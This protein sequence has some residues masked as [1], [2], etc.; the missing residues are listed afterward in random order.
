M[1]KIEAEVLEVAAHFDED[2][3]KPVLD[4]R[5]K[6]RL[7]LESV[8]DMSNIEGDDKVE[9]L[10]GHEVAMALKRFDARNK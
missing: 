4:V 2:T 6:M 8:R 7:D 1:N 5:F 10:F 3:F 9:K